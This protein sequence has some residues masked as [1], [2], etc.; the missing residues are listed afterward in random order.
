MRRLALSVLWLV[1][2]ALLAAGRAALASPP[3]DTGAL[4]RRFEPV[5]YF[6][7]REDWSPELA[8]GFVGRA[9]VEK[10]IGSNT[11]AA[12]PA[13]LPMNLDGCSFDPCYR[14]NLLCAL[15]RGDA[16]Y[17]RASTTVTD[18]THPLIYGRVVP[19]P[20]GTTAPAGFATVPRYF[21]R[22]WLFFEF[23]DW[24]SQHEHLWQT[25]EGD[26]ESSTEPGVLRSL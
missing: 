18:W 12:V 3:L 9:L 15:K 4:L 17:Q 1:L 21:V 20:A 11:W 7:P 26:W 14:F 10:Q 19:V 24:R 25:H 5:L 23:D 2:A 22:Y 6:H 16:C 13:P 8:D